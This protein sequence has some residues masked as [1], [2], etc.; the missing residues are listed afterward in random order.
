MSVGPLPFVALQE[1]QAEGARAITG[2]GIEK[3]GATVVFDGYTN[4]RIYAKRARYP[5]IKMSRCIGQV[6]GDFPGRPYD[7]LGRWRSRIYG[8]GLRIPNFCCQLK[9]SCWVSMVVMILM[10]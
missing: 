8:G 5:G 9:P 10:V 1:P 3:T 6:G 7:M 4:W 2:S